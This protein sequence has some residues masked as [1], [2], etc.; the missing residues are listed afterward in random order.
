MWQ[1]QSTYA[2]PAT[3]SMLEDGEIG[4]WCVRT[5]DN[6]ALYDFTSI[7]GDGIFQ[8]W[9]AASPSERD[10]AAVGVSYDVTTQPSPGKATYQ[11]SEQEQ[12]RDLFGQPTGATIASQIKAGIK[13]VA[14]T[15]STMDLDVRFK[16]EAVKTKAFADD[17]LTLLT[18]EET[19]Q[20]VS[21]ALTTTKTQV[22]E[23]ETQVESMSTF[24]TGGG[25]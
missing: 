22:S 18:D 5:T 17:E 3:F 7:G 6:R 12:L 24:T 9:F 4:L 19:G 8:T 13:K 23:T 15:I 20:G 2:S 21:I 16:S 11:A 10:T 1:K 25:Y 14:T